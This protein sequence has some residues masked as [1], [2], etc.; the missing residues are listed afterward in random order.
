MVTTVHAPVHIHIIVFLHIT[1]LV[2][3][4]TLGIM[5]I[6]I[7]SLQRLRRNHYKKGQKYKFHNSIIHIIL[8]NGMAYPILKGSV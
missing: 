3:G 1:M 5:H 7:R 4:G 2:M 6:A 8:L